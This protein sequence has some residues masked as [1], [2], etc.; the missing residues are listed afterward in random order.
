MSESSRKRPRS[1]TGGEAAAKPARRARKSRFAPATTAP[2][3]TRTPR[4]KAEIAAAAAAAVA[5]SL[6][7]AKAQAAAA[8]AAQTAAARSVSA[9]N[10]ASIAQAAADA[11]AKAQRNQKIQAAL[12]SIQNAKL[13]AGSTGV[14]PTGKLVLDNLGRQVDQSGRVLGFQAV[15]TLAAN[16]SNAKSRRRSAILNPYMSGMGAGAS[17][18][19]ANA[20]PPGI[21]DGSGADNGDKDDAAPADANAPFD[22]RMAGGNR[23][24]GRRRAGLKFAEQG[25]FIK[26]AASQRAR[27]A[28]EAAIE[29]AHGP[30][31]RHA[32]RVHAELDGAAA[33]TGNANLVAV[34]RRRDALPSK[35]S[36]RTPAVEWWDIEF[37]PAEVRKER[38]E[39]VKAKAKPPAISYDQ[40]APEHCVTLS[41]GLIELPVPVAPINQD[42]G[43]TAVPLMLT[44]KERKRLRRQTRA[45]RL[46]EQQDKVA[47]RLIPPPAPKVKLKNMMLVRG[48]DAVM[49]PTQVEAQ[50]RAEMEKRQRNHEMRNLARS[51]VCSAP[52]PARNCV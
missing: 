35:P 37:L 27:E 22:P 15:A 1:P 47:L 19:G 4:S 8:A 48:N 5:K 49:D 24:G 36:T 2:A 6:A 17:A 34:G 30:G 52:V 39:A 40:C 23:P 26:Q 3:P 25:K 51:V 45:E 16:R 46:K 9:K 14:A 31:S 41:S 50:V 28:R 7:T 32:P 18:T 10:A 13:L 44:K 21:S 43:P 29:L 33:A 38:K 20:A 12:A 42:N 11:L